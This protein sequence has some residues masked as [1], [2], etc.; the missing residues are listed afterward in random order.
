M[1]FD[2]NGNVSAAI[3]ATDGTHTARYEY[4]PFGGTT[5]ATGSSS[6]LLPFQFSTKYL[7]TE[8]GLYYYGYRFYNP[9][10]GRWI[11]RDPIEERG[12]GICMAL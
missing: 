8:T 10:T 3:N 6:E 11:N 1:A 4:D 5:T 7:D 2:G 9:E 12:D